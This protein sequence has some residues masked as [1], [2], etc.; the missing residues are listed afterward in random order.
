MFFGEVGFGGEEGI[1]QVSSVTVMVGRNIRSAPPCAVVG[2]EGEG[3]VM[4]EKI[5]P[6]RTE[7]LIS[8]EDL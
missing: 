2:A 3:R 1:E 4:I 5:E 7:I 8:V 6:Q